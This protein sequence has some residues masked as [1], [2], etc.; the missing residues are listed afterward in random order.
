MVNK[1]TALHNTGQ[2]HNY[3]KRTI[4]FPQFKPYRLVA[5]FFVC[6]NSCRSLNVYCVTNVTISKVCFCGRQGAK[7]GIAP[8]SAEPRRKKYITR[9]QNEQISPRQSACSKLKLKLKSMHENVLSNRFKAFGFQE[10]EAKQNRRLREDFIFRKTKCI[11]RTTKYH[12]STTR[13]LTSLHNSRGEE[14]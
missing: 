14:L 11:L 1:S 8:P 7:E 3:R 4:T 9:F 10:L 6:L 12:I 2:R 5:S 13:T